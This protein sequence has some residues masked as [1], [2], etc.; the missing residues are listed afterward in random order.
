M[1]NNPKAGPIFRKIWNFLWNDDSTWSW[2]ANIIVAFLIIK[3]IL[4]PLL[5]IILGTNFP[6][7]AV[8]SESMEHSIHNQDL[9]GQRFQ[10][11]QESFDN[12]WQVCGSWYGG[13]GISK[14]R[15]LSFPFPNGFDKGDVIILWRA[16]PN[17]L[18]IGDILVFKGGR[19]QPI[20]H[21]VV[22][23]W[24]E[25]GEFYYQTKGDH[26]G[27]SLGGDLDETKID[28]ERI[29]GKGILRIPYLGWMKIIFVDAVKP[30]GINIER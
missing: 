10:E 4:Y 5:G 1:K 8:I 22:K 23:A 6:L 2:L 14:E 21:R 13:Q 11:F 17:N 26:N 16:N 7:V 28:K 24:L 27:E 29:L 19:P 30:L 3:F 18:K 9:C 15:F 12:Y 20:I 25:E